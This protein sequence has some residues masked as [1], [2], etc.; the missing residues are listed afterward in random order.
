[1]VEV[2]AILSISAATG[3]RIALPLLLI[4]LLQ[5][6]SLWSSVPLLSQV[7]PPL[8]LGVLVS[9]SLV[10]L[11]FSKDRL[12]Q[13]LLQ[14]VELACS[15]VV[16]AIAGIT[17]A[18]LM[19]TSQELVPVAALVSGLLAL[20][21]QLVQVGWFYRLRGLPLWA[22]F[23][24]DFLCVL[25]VLFAFDAPRQGGLIALLLLWLAIR[26]T[27]EWRQW[28]QAQANG[29]DRRFPRRGKQDPD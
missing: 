15:P 27:A 6:E 3:M 22:I 24:Q 26:S 9:W 8:V 20:V 5:R 7:P 18:R 1:M 29:G 23:L 12:A 14:I 17:V 2:L 13:R 21:F 25:L 11:L 16:G 10:E 4:G 19:Q 28:Y